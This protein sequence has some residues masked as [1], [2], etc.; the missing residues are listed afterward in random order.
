MGL[1]PGYVVD[2]GR[3]HLYWVWRTHRSGKGPPAVWGRG[4]VP[5]PPCKTCFPRK[6]N[7]GFFPRA[8]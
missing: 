3:I 6:K 8:P 1:V 5:Y 2:E 7:Q 4:E